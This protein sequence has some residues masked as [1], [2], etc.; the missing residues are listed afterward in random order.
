[1]SWTT[2]SENPFGHPSRCGFLSRGSGRAGSGDEHVVE[3][4]PVPLVVKVYR[5]GGTGVLDR[6]QDSAHK[7]SIAGVLDVAAEGHDRDFIGG[8]V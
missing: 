1:M 8:G 6:Y 2:R 7:V 3:H 5:R 4:L